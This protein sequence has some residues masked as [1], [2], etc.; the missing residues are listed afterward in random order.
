MVTSK[1]AVSLLEGTLERFGYSDLEEAF[2]D[3]REGDLSFDAEAEEF[4]IDVFESAGIDR[5]C[6]VCTA[7]MFEVEDGWYCWRCEGTVSND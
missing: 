4:A 1:P 2:E 6:P 7:L 5:M 3:F